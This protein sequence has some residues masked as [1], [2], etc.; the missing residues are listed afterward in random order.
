MHLPFYWLPILVTICLILSC[1]SQKEKLSA[2]GYPE[3]VGRI[4]IE[5][6]AT[7]GCHNDQSAAAAAGLNLETWTDLFKGSRG[8]SPVIPHSPELSYLLFSVNTD[9]TLGSTLTPTMPYNE[10]P[11]TAQQYATLWNWVFD[12][13]PNAS[14]ASRFPDD[15]DRQ[16]WYIGHQICDQVAV[17]DA[18]SQQLMRYVDVG[19]D[20]V[21]VE[22]VFDIKLSPDGQDWFVVFF[23]RQG[24]HFSF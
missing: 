2:S 6:C 21:S 20:P 3:D 19:V 9:S 5:N 15:P 10:A 8:G 13:A 14:G 11:L 23:W 24:L 7:Q 1:Q 4:L 22:F 16:K 12:G 18:T 17:F